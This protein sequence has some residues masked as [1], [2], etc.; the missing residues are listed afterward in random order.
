MAPS[1]VLYFIGTRTYSP[2]GQLRMRGREES[3]TAT[4]LCA[5]LF[6]NLHTKAHVGAGIH[7]YFVITLGIVK[8]GPSFVLKNE[9]HRRQYVAGADHLQQVPADLY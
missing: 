6:R 8:Q 1:L 2:P 4:P 3:F 7:E 9:R 5:G